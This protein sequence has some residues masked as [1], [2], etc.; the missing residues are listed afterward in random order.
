MK[1]LSLHILDIA[2][3]ATQSGAS[4]VEITVDEDILK[5]RLTISIKDNGRGMSKE[6]LQKVKDP[7]TTTRT[8]RSVGLGIPFFEMAAELCGGKLS[9]DSVEGKGT[10]ITAWFEY[11]HIDRQPLGDMP[12]T[13]MAAVTGSPEVDFIYRHVICG[14]EFLLDTREIKKVLK[15]VPI[16]NVEVATWLFEYVSEGLNMLRR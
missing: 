2:K 12:S 15:G 8:T 13:I 11:D 4:L 1:E 9:I 14:K 3:N 6:L 16:N 7:F 5:N 10:N